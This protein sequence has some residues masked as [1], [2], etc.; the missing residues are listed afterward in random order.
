[1]TTAAA[2]AIAIRC[3]HQQAQQLAWDAN[4]HDKH[5][6][7]YPQAIAASKKRIQ[8]KQAIKTLQEFTSSQGRAQ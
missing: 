8:L 3:L 1:M 5:G 2:I 6:A 4:M 7:D